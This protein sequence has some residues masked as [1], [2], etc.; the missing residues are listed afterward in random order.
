MRISYKRK[1]S[2][3]HLFQ[4]ECVDQKRDRHACI[5]MKKE[6]MNLNGGGGLVLIWYRKE[7][8]KIFTIANGYK[9]W[10]KISKR[11][12]THFVSVFVCIPLISTDLKC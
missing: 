10:L 9:V 1:I 12:L 5:Q 6:I 4:L 3:S 11:N 2:Q 8:W 7:E